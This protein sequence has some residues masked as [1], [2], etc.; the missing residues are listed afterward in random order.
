[1]SFSHETFMSKTKFEGI[2]KERKT[3]P[4]NRTRLAEVTE[5]FWEEAI[6]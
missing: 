6:S 5:G 3:S 2:F 1:M 4:N